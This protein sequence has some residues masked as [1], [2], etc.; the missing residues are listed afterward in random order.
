MTTCDEGYG[1][2]APPALLQMAWPVAV[3]AL[4]VF[5][6]VLWIGVLG[7]LLVRLLA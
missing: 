3:L 7:Y 5:A 6:N 1:P 2:G 4:A